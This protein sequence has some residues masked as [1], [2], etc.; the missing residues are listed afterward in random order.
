M[1][2]S[3]LNKMTRRFNS[4]DYWRQRYA[5]GGNSGSGSYGRLA[6]YKAQF[7]NDFVSARSARSV[8][9][10]GFGDGAQA[11]MFTF[12]NYIGIDVVPELVQRASERFEDREGWS[13]MTFDQYHRLPCKADLG[14]SLDVIYHLVE[15]DI[16]DRYMATLFDSAERFVLIYSS[17]ADDIPGSTHVRH[18]RYS[19]WVVEN[20]PDFKRTACWP[21]PYPASEHSDWTETSFASFQLYEP[22]SLLVN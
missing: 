17:D 15:D 14:L 22:S 2:R 21:N 20:R 1:I 16:F 13:F 12:P 19:D 6:E 10:I 7:V 4:G 11:S 18:R 3:M 5:Q 8:I 9:E